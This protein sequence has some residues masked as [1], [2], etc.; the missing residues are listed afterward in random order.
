MFDPNNYFK[1]IAISHI[2]IKHTE[3]KPAFFREY[4]SAK[5]LINNSDLLEKMR[6][7]SNII[8]VSQFNGEKKFADTL[9]N[10]S[11][12]YIGSVFLLK[13][14]IKQVDID[15]IR[16]ELSNVWEDIFARIKKE[17]RTGQLKIGEVEAQ[18][19]PVGAITDNYYGI[20]VFFSYTE[21]N[22]HSYNKN[23]WT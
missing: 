22:C 20:A 18:Q 17:I 12:T 15:V 3:E 21:I 14:I 7:A 10:N 11:K 4:S 23:K 9:D 19:T 5:I 1:N 8:L 16:N 6:Y 13:K 2:D